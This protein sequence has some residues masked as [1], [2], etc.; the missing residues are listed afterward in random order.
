MKVYRNSNQNLNDIEPS[1]TL[2]DNVSKLISI[3]SARTPNDGL[4]SDSAEV[5]VSV[6]KY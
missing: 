3:M 1:T 2:I 5:Q 4:K 6:S